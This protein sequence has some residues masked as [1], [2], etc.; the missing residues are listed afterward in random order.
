MRQSI[1][2]ARG[3]LCF[4]LAAALC[5]NGCSLLI[6]SHARKKAT[7]RRQDADVVLKHGVARS[8][9]IDKLGDP[10]ETVTLQGLRTD[11]YYLRSIPEPSEAS[12]HRWEMVDWEFLLVPEIVM[13]PAVIYGDYFST[14]DSRRC[15]VSYGRDER[16][17]RTDCTI[18]P[19]D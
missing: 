9:V 8:N 16:I 1:A 10:D 13:T 14:G 12:L 15:R 2:T 19:S 3:L 17:T 18:L 4:T 6:D 5:S 7:E 11:T